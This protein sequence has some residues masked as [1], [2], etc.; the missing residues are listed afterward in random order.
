MPEQITSSASPSGVGRSTAICQDTWPRLELTDLG[1][2][3][4]N[5]FQVTSRSELSTGSTLVF[6][7][8]E[9]HLRLL[10]HEQP[11]LPLSLLYLTQIALH[12]I[13]FSGVTLDTIIQS[14]KVQHRYFAQQ[15][16]CSDKVPCFVL[17][18][19]TTLLRYLCADAPASAKH[20]VN[21]QKKAAAK[22][23]R[24]H[25]CGAF[26]LA[27]SI[28][29]SYVG[30]GEVQQATSTDD[31]SAWWPMLHLSVTVLAS[32]PAQREDEGQIKGVSHFT[33]V[34]NRLSLQ[35]IE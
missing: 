25:G 17:C 18:T 7:T 10:R 5:K 30:R 35:E 28:V 3:V 16:I 6:S 13:V 12:S 1:V 23:R 31:P 34:S 4:I 14:H 15:K 33:F 19:L 8:A 22:G 32:Q 20:G 2:I 29:T 11:H 24:Q 26:G 9:I 21:Y 27:N